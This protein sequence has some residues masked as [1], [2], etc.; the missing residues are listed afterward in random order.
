MDAGG[1]LLSSRGEPL[2][3]EAGVTHYYND[4][5]YNSH[6]IQAVGHN[7]MLVDGNPESQRLPDYLWVP[8]LDRRPQWGTV[9]LADAADLFETE[10]RA[11]YTAPLKVTAAPW[12]SSPGYFVFATGSPRANNIRI[13]GSSTRR[14]AGL[15][16]VE[17]GGFSV[18]RSGAPCGRLGATS[19]LEV[20]ERDWPRPGRSATL[21]R[22]TGSAS[23]RAPGPSAAFVAV[24][25][26]LGPAETGRR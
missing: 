14:R 16:E 2:L 7:V 1:F 10:L 4:P 26:P 22:G 15:I 3:S 21:R 8:A 19:P 9:L 11:V 5:H 25:C 13:R 24:L 23:K 17:P 12:S 18:E 6:F 20:R